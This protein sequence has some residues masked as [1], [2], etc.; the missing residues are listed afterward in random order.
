MTNQNINNRIK[1][2]QKTLIVSQI[3]NN[4]EYQKLMELKK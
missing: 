4:W 3:K 1:E 2:I